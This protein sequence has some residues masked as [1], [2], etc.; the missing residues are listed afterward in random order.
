MKQIIL[1][2]TLL[3][4]SLPLV[5]QDFIDNA[6]LFS[7]TQRS[8]SARI[9]AVGGAQTALGGDYSSALSNPA[10]L[11]MYNRGEFTF[12]AGMS[13]L[14]GSST[15]FGETST[16]TKTPFN[17]PGLSVVIHTPSKHETGFLGG[18]FG[19]SISRVNDFQQ[20]FQ[21]DAN[22][23]G[24]SIIDYFIEDAGTINPDEMLVV[25]GNMGS[26][27]K[28]LTG[29]AYNNYL[30]DE[31]ESDN[32]TITGYNSILNFSQSRE[33]EVSERTGGQYQWSFAYGA[34]FSDKVFAGVNFG[35]STI[36]YKLVQTYREDSFVF[37]PDYNPITDFSMEEEFNIQGTGFS[38]TFGTIYRPINMLQIGLSYST[39]TSYSIRDEYFASMESNWLEPEPENVYEDFREAD[40]IE[41][42]LVTPGKLRTG[43]TFIGKK[44]FITGDVEFVD[45]S[46]AKYKN[47]DDSYYAADNNPDIA[48]ELNNAV[49]FAVGGEYRLNNLRLRLGW[50]LMQDPYVQSDF[51]TN[52][53]DRKITSYSSGVGYRGK[54]FFVD[55]TGIYSTTEGK[56][57]PY[58]LNN[59]EDPF[60]IQEFK[61]FRLMTTIGFNF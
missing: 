35:V 60:A 25:N 16:A 18:A 44:G 45:Y 32:G 53:V 7:R 52:P 43:I 1:A 9:Q 6:L 28:T 34:N 10:G 37:P 55:L 42:K 59:S 3:I 39:P 41:Y 13:F 46:K 27:F 12:S 17:I 40:A 22:V 24:I 58:Y 48:A 5:A 56:R 26:Y 29:L 33:K 4:F 20:V 23:N 61:S 8:G 31:I 11:G 38:G 54:K 49:N 50:N 15:Y 19:I 14:E 2:V 57:V 36:S 47:K 30:I 21:Y 51:D